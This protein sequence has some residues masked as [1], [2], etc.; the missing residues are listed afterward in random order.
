MNKNFSKWRSRA[1]PPLEVLFQAIL[2]PCL[3]KVYVASISQMSPKCRKIM[4][5]PLYMASFSKGF[6]VAK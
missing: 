3:A 1:C 5:M 2:D 6:L 4:V